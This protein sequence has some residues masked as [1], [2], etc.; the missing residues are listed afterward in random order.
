MSRAINVTARALTAGLGAAVVATA[1]ATTSV[2]ASPGRASA[3]ASPVTTTSRSAH[4][5]LSTAGGGHVHYALVKPLCPAPSNVHVD[6]CLALQKVNVSKATK[7]AV[8][9][10]QPSAATSG[11][12]GGY[13]PADLASAYGINPAAATTQTVAI[14]DAYDDPYALRELNAFNA[15][16]GLPA[17]SATSFRKVNQKG[18]TAPLPAADPGWAGEIAL[19]IE[20]VRGVCHRCKI[21]LVEGTTPTS[22]NLATAVNTAVRLGAKVI[23]NSYGGPE[24][25]IHGVSSGRVQ[26]PGR[27]HHG[28]DRRSRLVR[29]GFRQRLRRRVGQHAEHAG[30]VP[31]RGSR[32]RDDPAA[33]SRWLTSAGR[34]LEPRRH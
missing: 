4:P 30:L 2:A 12:V 15:H 17:E 14:V 34:R 25:R 18:A 33:E 16:Y 10:V 27:P 28:L 3:S 20:T 21:L 8:A 7:G 26:P 31:E 5:Q 11:P 1:L 19:D 22:N 24:A 6:R 9:Y 29:L 32:R 13:T 23:S